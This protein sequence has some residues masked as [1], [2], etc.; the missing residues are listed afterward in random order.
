MKPRHPKHKRGAVSVPLTLALEIDGL[1]GKRNRSA[2]AVETI[3]RYLADPELLA[4][5][6]LKRRDG[7]S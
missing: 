7:Q 3:R 2:F 5:L 1:V 6:A 4:V